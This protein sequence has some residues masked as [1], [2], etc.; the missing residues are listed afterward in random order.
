MDATSGAEP[1]STTFTVTGLTLG[2]YYLIQARRAPSKAVVSRD[3]AF[4]V[5][6]ANRALD[7][8]ALTDLVPNYVEAE[9]GSML[10]LCP[11]FKHRLT[12]LLHYVL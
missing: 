5:A 9:I 11:A 12:S 10:Q 1:T 8:N 3:G 2:Y 4:Q 6:A 7:T